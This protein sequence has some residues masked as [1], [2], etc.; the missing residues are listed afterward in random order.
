M[1]LTTLCRS[2]FFLAALGAAFSATAAWLELQ[3]GYYTDY[4]IGTARAEGG[5]NFNPS[6]A[7]YG[8]VDFYGKRVN[9]F[10]LSTY[11]GEIRFMQSLGP[12]DPKLKKWNLTFEAN[13]GT[14]YAGIGRLGLVWNTSFGQGNAFALKLYPIATRDH[15]AQAAI[16]ISQAFTPKLSGFLVFD[17]G[18]GDWIFRQKQI[19]VEA[20]LRYRVTKSFS[21]FAQGRQF[22]PAASFKLDLTPVIGVK[23]TL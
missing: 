21:L 17:Y 7:T 23:F 22:E 10:D 1:S 5:G 11:Y 6:L 18:F 14:D 2:V 9:K 19:Y 12:L 8:F 15:D 13:G 16:F 20:E 4:A 3:P